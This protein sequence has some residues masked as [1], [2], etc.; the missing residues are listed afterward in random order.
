MTRSLCLIIFFIACTFNPLHA[1]LIVAPNGSGDTLARAIMGPSATISNI[2]FRCNTGASGFA[3]GTNSNLPLDTSVVL[4]NGLITSAMGP[5][6]NPATSDVFAPPQ[7]GD[8]ILS[9]FIPD[10]IPTDDAC[11]LQFRYIPKVSPF[12]VRYVFASDEYPEYVCCPTA[13]RFGFFIL[14]PNP[15]GMGPPNYFYDD[16]A[17]IPNSNPPIPTLLNTV[18]PGQM[19]SAPCANPGGCISLSNSL[20]YNDNTGSATEEFD[21]YTDALQGEVPVYPCSTYTIRF[22]IADGGSPTVNSYV[23]I[24]TSSQNAQPYTMSL[25]SNLS[26]P[27]VI[28]GCLGGMLTITIAN[29]NPFDL[30]LLLDHYGSAINGVDYSLPDTAVIPAGA[31]SVSF[32]FTPFLDSLLENSDTIKIALRLPCTGWLDSVKIAIKDSLTLSVSPPQVMCPGDTIQI[33]ANSPGMLQWDPAYNI[34]NTIV[35]DPLVYPAVDTVYSV[36]A[37]LLGCQSTATVPVH[38]R[39]A[40]FVDAGPDTGNCAGQFLYLNAVVGPDVVVHFWSPPTGLSNITLLDPMLIPGQ[41]RY[42]TLWVRDIFGCVNTDS[43]FVEVYP[44]PVVDAGP[45]KSI[46]FGDS[47]QLDASGNGT[48]EWSPKSFIADFTAEDPWVFPDQTTTFQL[49]LTDSNGCRSGDQV[50]VKVRDLP[51]VDAGPDI[52]ICVNDT[53]QLTASGAKTYYWEAGPWLLDTVGPSVG[54]I[55]VVT[56]DFVVY[57]TD[58]YNCR[59][60]DTVRVYTRNAPPVSASAGTLSACPG[61][62]VFLSASGAGDR[63]KWF[64]SALIFQ[65]DSSST[66]AVVNETTRFLVMTTDSLG[67]RGYDSVW[68]TVHA[69]PQINT[70]DGDSICLGESI[71]LN[72]G[73]GVLYQWSPAASLSDP[74]SAAPVA[75]PLTTTTYTLQVQNTYGCSGTDSTRIVVLPLPQASAG[76]DTSICLGSDALLTASGGKSYLWQPAFLLTCDT[77]RISNAHPVSTRV[78]TLEVTDKFGCKD[79]D[80]VTVNVLSLPVPNASS[81][82]TDICYGDSVLLEASGGIKYR[83]EP[84]V[85]LDQPAMSTSLARP[86][87]T[88][89][90]TVF[91]SDQHSCQGIDS[92]RVRVHG[93]PDAIVMSDDSICTG[94]SI[95]LQAAGGSIYS[96]SPGSYLNDSTLPDPLANPPSTTTFTVLVRDALGCSSRDELTVHVLPLPLVSAAAGSELCLGDS[97]RLSAGGAKKYQ[98]T[99]AAN[100]SCSNCQ[101]PWWKADQSTTFTVWGEDAFGCRNFDTSRFVVRALPLVSAGPDTLICPEQRVRLSASGA[102]DFLWSPPLY[103]DNPTA[104]SPLAT[105]ADP[106]QYTV[107]GTDLFGCRGRDSVNILFFP[108][109]NVSAGPDLFICEGDSVELQGSGADFYEWNP[110]QWL[111]DSTKARPLARPAASTLFTVKGSSSNGCLSTD[112]VLVTVYRLPSLSLSA[113]SLFI[114]PGDTTS[115]TA[116]GADTYRWYPAGFVS[117]SSA[118]SVNLYPEFSQIFTLEAFSAEGCLEKRTVFVKVAPLVDPGAR[119][120]E[121]SICLGDTL[122]L[123]AAPGYVYRWFPEEDFV[124]PEARDALA[125]PG[126][127]RIYV[128]ELR[129][130]F[131][132]PFYDSVTVFVLEPAFADAGPD[133]S[134]YEGESIRLNG[135]GNGSFHWFPSKWLDNAGAQAPLATPDSSIT[136]TLIVTTDNECTAEDKVRIRVFLETQ[137]WFANAFSP[138]GDGKNDFFGPEIYNEIEM[139]YFAIYD[140]W[141]KRLFFTQTPGEKWDGRIQGSPAPMGTY[142][143][144]FK[145]KGNRSK[146]FFRHGNFTLI[147]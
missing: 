103:L 5:N 22:A 143:Y 50:K 70:G 128:L 38:V 35:E 80:Q 46:C 118:A 109:S 8:T 137:V 120:K 86:D 77:C 115:L 60:T 83:W 16:F 107:T 69:I 56:S 74:A 73:G 23:F 41:S 57:G 96:W 65:P 112:E 37:T 102:A 61:D 48:F 138:N 121:V 78:F 58:K 62:T 147:R 91:V 13:D 33:E 98:W 14:G 20:L 36:T 84:A 79:Q 133:L 9:G 119:P 19:G 24:E 76:Q 127:D 97:L 134:I 105:P 87:T 101:D 55:P 68:V 11:I 106:I 139:E 144:E 34:S 140:R 88:T 53:V 92:V 108:G 142:I 124:D 99:P 122:Q 67:C 95:Q 132:C 123:F 2:Y 136:Y 82:R 125:V 28:E 27:Y 135:Q 32:P 104:S 3:L 90:F 131:N 94:S 145:A 114:C 89:W 130:S 93:L 117:D 72:A 18:N 21:G 66:L 75:T 51:P 43:V 25:T 17:V 126:S 141:G 31:T 116:G 110:A 4:S 10:T 111:D 113:D 54:A 47:V 71:Q 44:F 49:F 6:I 30:T 29:D 15:T 59:N 63:Y 1:Q 39:E 81:S 52:T 26:A 85:L 45:N 100:L 129:D 42:Y 64:S 40:P 7:D 12:S 146:P